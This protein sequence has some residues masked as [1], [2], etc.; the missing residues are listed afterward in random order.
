[1]LKLREVF[2]DLGVQYLL[3][4]KIIIFD[5]VAANWIFKKHLENFKWI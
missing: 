2:D 4:F 3:T 1:M 5:S